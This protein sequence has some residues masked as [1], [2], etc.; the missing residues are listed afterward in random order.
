MHASF[1]KALVL[2]STHLTPKPTSMWLTKFH[3][4]ILA[5]SIQLQPFIPAD[6]W[7]STSSPQVHDLFA[8]GTSNGVMFVK[9]SL[10]GGHSPWSILGNVW[11]TRTTATASDVFAVEF[12]SPS[13]LLVGQ[14]HGG[15]DLMDLRHEDVNRHTESYLRHPSCVTHIRRVD[16]WHVVV[17]GLENSVCLSIPASPLGDTSSRSPSD[18]PIQPSYEC[19]IFAILILDHR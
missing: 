5:V 17:N 3:S 8:L 15:V 14:R 18:R 2:S 4:A 9:V 12:T 13:T 10:D 7:A 19:T 11:E 16:D 6:I 1:F